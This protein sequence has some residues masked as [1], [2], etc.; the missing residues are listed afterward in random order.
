MFDE[1]KHPR[2]RKG[3]FA[4][5]DMKDLSADELKEKILSGQ[6]S[7]AESSENYQDELST[8]LGEEFKGVKGQDAIDKIMKEKRGHVKAAFHRDDIGDID[9]IWGNG[10]VG[11]SHIIQQRETE[12]EGH[13]EEILS[14]LSLA[15]E[16]GE[17]KKKNDRGNFEFVHKENGLKYLVIIA[18]EY[19]NNK[20]TY[21]LSAFRRGK[22][23]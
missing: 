19:H 20:M 15:T 10:N 1:T 18:P 17:F 12:K 14:H 3:Q 5:K 16:K 2:D 6:N 21:V 11:L 7:E 9:L 4:E 8:L 23:R 22:K 13:V